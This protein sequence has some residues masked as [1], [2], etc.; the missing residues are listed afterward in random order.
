MSVTLWSNE[1]RREP[2]YHLRTPVWLED[3]NGRRIVATTR[4]ISDHGLGLWLAGS[5]V[6]GGEAV[7]VR[8]QDE[9]VPAR[10][11][12]A[13]SAGRHNESWLGLELEHGITESQARALLTLGSLG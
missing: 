9:K 8:F 3:G 2:R 1:K 12:H 5:G 7:M 6:A 4:D 11:R 13:E 10:V